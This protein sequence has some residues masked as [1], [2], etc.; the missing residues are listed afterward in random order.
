MKDI[1]KKSHI[2]K[3]SHRRCVVGAFDNFYKKYLFVMD[4][5]LYYLL[6]YTNLYFF[7]LY[8]MVQSLMIDI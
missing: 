6:S 7:T 4:T 8:I 5:E 2:L 3:H 1:G